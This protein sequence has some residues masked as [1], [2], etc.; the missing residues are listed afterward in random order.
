MSIIVLND[1]IGLNVVLENIYDYKLI[2]LFLFTLLVHTSAMIFVW[3]TGTMYYETKSKT[4]CTLKMYDIIH[5]NYTDYTRYNYSKNV[6]LLSFLLPILWN[7]NKLTYLAFV[8]FVIKFCIIFLLRS[9]VI[10]STIPPKQSTMR[11]THL[12]LFHI[13]CAGT[14]YDKMFSGHYST[15]LLLSILT[16]KHH[17]VTSTLTNIFTYIVLNLV[18]FIII[19]ITRSHY[20]NDLIISLYITCGVNY[21]FKVYSL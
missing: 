6:Y 9:F 17:I 14:F 12:N 20:T 13:L 1:D 3:K 2:M 10:I 21:L 11:I 15:G 8:E 16:L 19:S 4:C 5:S 18:H 7:I